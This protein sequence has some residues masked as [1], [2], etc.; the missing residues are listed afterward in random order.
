LQSRTAAFRDSDAQTFLDLRP[1]K[2]SQLLHSAIR[3]INHRPEKV[4][5]HDFRSTVAK[6][7]LQCRRCR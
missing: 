3:N 2:R 6:L 4:L 5:R 1:D 7:V